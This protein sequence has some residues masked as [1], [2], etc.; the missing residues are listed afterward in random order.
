M[1]QLR[2][3]WSPSLSNNIQWYNT[4][5]WSKPLGFV[6]FSSVFRNNNYCLKQRFLRNN[7][8]VIYAV[9]NIWDKQKHLIDSRWDDIWSKWDLKQFCSNMWSFI[10]VYFLTVRI[11]NNRWI[12]GSYNVCRGGL[13]HCSVI[14]LSIGNIG[15]IIGSSGSNS[16]NDSAIIVPYFFY[17]D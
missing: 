12:R 4:D 10:R 13:L 1:T 6:N 15:N 16:G 2:I 9:W 8:N 14:L 7:G 5:I 11:L 17:I 3:V